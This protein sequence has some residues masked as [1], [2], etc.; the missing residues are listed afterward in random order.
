MEHFEKSYRIIWNDDFQYM[1]WEA[2]LTPEQFAH[3]IL[4]QVAGTQVDAVFP[5]VCMG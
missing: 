1:A 2:P 5:T 3:V 4:G